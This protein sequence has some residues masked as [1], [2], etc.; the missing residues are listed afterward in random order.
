[1]T[2][3]NILSVTDKLNPK[4]C[5]NILY[6]IYKA[7]FF[8]HNQSDNMRTVL[9]ELCRP[10]RPYDIVEYIMFENKEKFFF[11]ITDITDTHYVGYKISYK[12]DTVIE[13]EPYDIS[14]DFVI[15][16]VHYLDD[17]TKQLYLNSIKH[18]TRGI[19]RTVY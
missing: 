9:K 4:D 3:D 13:Q 10:I 11:F 6:N 2:T 14:K 12:N 8:C 5:R 17:E 7:F 1:M 18:F 19:K 15:F 16:D